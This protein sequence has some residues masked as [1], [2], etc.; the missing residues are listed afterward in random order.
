MVNQEKLEEKKLYT[1]IRNTLKNGR[2]DLKRINR[3]IE[4][5]FAQKIT[6]RDFIEAITYP[7][8]SVLSER[9]HSSARNDQLIDSIITVSHES[10]KYN[11]EF[12]KTIQLLQE[13]KDFIERVFICLGRLEIIEYAAGRSDVHNSA[14]ILRQLYVDNEGVSDSQYKGI[15]ESWGRTN[16]YSRTSAFRLE[17]NALQKL[18]DLVYSDL[19]SWQILTTEPVNISPG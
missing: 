18:I 7:N 4:N 5:I 19:S 15:I 2:R 17:K 14:I 3:Q 12:T 1:D 8:L 16:N 6:E 13:K 11:F 9:V 10:E